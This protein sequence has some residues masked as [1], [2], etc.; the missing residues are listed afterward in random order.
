[1][2]YFTSYH[3]IIAFS[4]SKKV[5]VFKIV[6]SLLINLLCPMSALIYKESKGHPDK[7][8]PSM[9]LHMYKK[10]INADVVDMCDWNFSVHLFDNAALDTKTKPPYTFTWPGLSTVASLVV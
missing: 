9:Q 10:I 6:R 1:M 5:I 4:L 8:S 7:P 2:E 3:P